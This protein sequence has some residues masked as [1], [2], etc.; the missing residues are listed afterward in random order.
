MYEQ[1][2]NNDSNHLLANTLTI[3]RDYLVLPT[4]ATTPLPSIILDHLYSTFIDY[5]PIKYIHYIGHSY[6]S[7]TITLPS[8][9][10]EPENSTLPPLKIRNQEDLKLSNDMGN[11]NSFNSCNVNFH[12]TSIISNIDFVYA[13]TNIIS[14]SEFANKP[15]TGLLDSSSS[16][17][18]ILF[19]DT[20]LD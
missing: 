6:S 7:S 1:L 10:L 15:V 12:S 17:L 2:I 5:L 19:T 14:Q 11:L 8:T 3:S 18:L 20:D 9:A 16:L 4:H 13:N